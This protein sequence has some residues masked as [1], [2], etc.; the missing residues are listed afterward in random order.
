[1]LNKKK[2]FFSLHWSFNK[3]LLR[4]S[5]T[6]HLYLL[7]V[8]RLPAVFF[9]LVLVERTRIDEAPAAILALVWLFASMKSKMHLE[10]W[11]T[12]EAETERSDYLLF[13]CFSKFIPFMAVLAGELLGITMNHL[14]VAIVRA[15]VGKVL[16]YKGRN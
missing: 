16:D 14:H 3:I 11:F 6:T 1:M 15:L 7:L 4:Y 13:G 12:L 9:R 5:H 2:D 10:R 8:A